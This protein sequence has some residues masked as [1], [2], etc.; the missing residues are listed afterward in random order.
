MMLPW[1]IHNS[2]KRCPKH[3]HVM[4]GRSKL[5]EQRVVKFSSATE[6]L[7][8]NSMHPSTVALQLCSGDGGGDDG[9]GDD[10]GACREPDDS[11]SQILRELL[12]LCFSEP[13]DI[14]WCTCSL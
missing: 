9:G 11:V 4:L 12:S 5:P 2:A 8:T 7:F 6:R 14:G 1:A 10:G 13:D 3:A